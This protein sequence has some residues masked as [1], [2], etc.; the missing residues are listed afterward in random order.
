MIKVI[1]LI[2]FDGVGGVEV[3]ARSIG[4][5]INGDV[6]FEIRYIFEN[7]EIS[8]NCW[9]IFNPFRMVIVAWRLA[10]SDVDLLVVSL[11]RSSIVG[12]MAKFFRPKLKLITFLHLDKSV[13]YLDFI[14]TFLS[15]KFSIQ[16]WADS[17][18]TLDKRIPNLPIRNGR[19]I[20][21]VTHRFK[22]L[23]EK[24]VV[25][26]FVFWGRIAKQKNLILSIHLF[27]A[28]L[29]FH[30]DAKL[31]IIGPDA[32]ELHDIQSLCVSLGLKKSVLF[33]GPLSHNEIIKHA[34]KAS[35]YLQT[36]FS[37]GMAM[38]VVEAMQFGLVP[39]VTPVGEISSYCKDGINAVVV[40]SEEQTV[41]S[42]LGLLNGNDRYQ[43]IRRRAISTWLDKTI[44]KDSILMTCNDVIKNLNLR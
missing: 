29:K 24:H 9:S 26:S 37:E 19:I 21:F 20:S 25:P 1:H 30:P 16:I 3:A 27:S 31:T 42:I 44:Y 7:I 23:P 8:K 15:S 43:E 38:S 18:A 36:S 41:A 11:W 6:N 35:F 4:S 12:L 10:K 33:T 32:G 14:S 2:P 13:H 17:Q 40:T 22:S 34:H 28:V 5:A 39:V